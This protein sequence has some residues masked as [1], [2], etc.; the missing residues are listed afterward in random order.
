MNLQPHAVTQTMGEIFAITRRSDDIQGDIMGVSAA[1]T[2]LY[3]LAAR[4]IGLEHRIINQSHLVCN[5]VHRH[6]AGHIRMIALYQGAKIEGDEIS[7]L[8]LFGRGHAMRH[9]GIGAADGDNIKA[10]ALSAQTQHPVIQLG[11]QPLFR[12]A[13]TDQFQQ[14]IKRLLRNALSGYNM[15]HFLW[16][17]DLANFL[18]SAAQRDQLRFQLLFILAKFCHRQSFILINQRFDAMLFH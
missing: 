3:G 7:R 17:F 15:L 6:C 8:H 9:G 16:L 12:N 11:G 13:G 2:S 1:Q 10:H 18:Q 4:L 5:M 14:L